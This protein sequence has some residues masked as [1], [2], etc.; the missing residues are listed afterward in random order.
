[1]TEG[2][3]EQHM[4]SP[5]SS[6]YVKGIFEMSSSFQNHESF[7]CSKWRTGKWKLNTGPSLNLGSHPKKKSVTCIYLPTYLS[8]SSDSRESRDS[9][10]SSE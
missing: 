8:D 2:C 9:N 10:Y 1:M 7:K 3:V 5:G 6:S 4:A